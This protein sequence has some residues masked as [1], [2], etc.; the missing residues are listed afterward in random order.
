MDMS[1]ESAT[2]LSFLGQML[3][4]SPTPQASVSA[5]RGGHLWL[6][7]YI[8][9]FLAFTDGVVHSL[10]NLMRILNLT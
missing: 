8:F 2:S 9:I 1:C 5:W 7:A 4:Y 3:L 6:L 10:Q